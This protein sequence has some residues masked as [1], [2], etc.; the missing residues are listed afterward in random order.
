MATSLGI[1]AP[2]DYSVFVA[3]AGTWLLAAA[4][5][6]DRRMAAAELAGPAA[7]DARTD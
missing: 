3:A 1:R 2:L 4:I 6:Y 5:S 7:E